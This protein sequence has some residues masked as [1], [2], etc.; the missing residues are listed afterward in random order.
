MRFWRDTGNGLDARLQEMESFVLS[1]LRD[2]QS[3]LT[4]EIPRAK[5]E[6]AKHCTEITATPDGKS[7]RLSGDWDLVG[8]RSDGAGGGNWTERL[9]L[10]FE[11]QAAA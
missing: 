6:L 8:V 1:R 11:W 5:A 2:I 10:H 7:Y 4:G 9:P 3:I